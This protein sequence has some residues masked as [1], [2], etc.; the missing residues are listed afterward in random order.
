VFSGGNYRFQMLWMKIGRR[1]NNDRVN[2]LRRGNLLRSIR[3]DKKLRS[4]QSGEAFRLLDLI[5]VGVGLVELVLEKVA[6]RYN[7]SAAS[8]DHIRRILGAAAAAAKEPN[9]HSRIRC[10]TEGNLG[11]N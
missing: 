6:E 7:A 11:T 9:A 4:V 3:T 1:G 10:A 2:F 8:V 5:E